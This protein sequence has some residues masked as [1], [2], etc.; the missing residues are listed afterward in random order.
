MDQRGYSTDPSETSLNTP[1]IPVLRVKAW[2]TLA[3]R[4]SV[5]EAVPAQ[6]EHAAA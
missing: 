3:A 5:I 1:A 4:R 6:R 2:A